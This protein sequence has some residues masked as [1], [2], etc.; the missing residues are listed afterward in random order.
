MAAAGAALARANNNLGVSG[1]C[2]Q[3]T[4]L[5]I[6]ATDGSVYA[7]G[8]A[9]EYAAETGADIISNSWGYQIGSPRYRQC[10]HGNRKSGNKR[11]PRAGTGRPVRDDQ[12]HDGRTG[13]VTT[14]ISP[15][16]RM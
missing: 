8:L 13:K 11:P 12:F 4:F 1:T 3:C 10:R 6:R 15:R 2:P 7:Q 16:F 5:P 14:P 9:I